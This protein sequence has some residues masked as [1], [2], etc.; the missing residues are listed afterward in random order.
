LETHYLAASAETVAWGSFDAARATVLT[1]DPG[2]SSSS[3]RR[4][5]SPRT[6]RHRSPDSRCCPNKPK[7]TPDAREALRRMIG[8]LS[9]DYDMDRWD[10]HT[11]CS[12]AGDLRV[13]QLVD[14][15]KGIHAM[16]DKFAI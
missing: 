16:L 14:G 10:A 15:N 13:T 5:A 3:A 11:L 4:P 7:F 2:M 12:L 8:L 9:A 1:I 6:R